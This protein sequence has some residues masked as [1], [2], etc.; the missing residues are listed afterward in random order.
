[1]TGFSMESEQSCRTRTHG[2]SR[3]MSVLFFARSVFGLVFGITPMHFSYLKGENQSQK[4]GNICISRHLPSAHPSCKCSSW[5]SF[6]HAEGFCVIE[7]GD[8]L[9]ASK[10]LCVAAAVTKLLDD[11]P[12]E[13]GSCRI[14]PFW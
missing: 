12:T 2:S 13:G 1:M 3:S 11:V 4:G 7:L 5:F 10:R 8:Q 14:V 6:W 9:R